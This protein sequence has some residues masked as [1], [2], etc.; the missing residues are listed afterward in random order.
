MAKASKPTTLKRTL[1]VKP[2]RAEKPTF[3]IPAVPATTYVP[4]SNELYVRLSDFGASRGLDVETLARIAL[5][6]LLRAGRFYALDTPLSFGQYAG[7]K[8]ETVIRLNPGY[9]S[10]AIE[11]VDGMCLGEGAQTLLDQMLTRDLEAAD[12]DV[13]L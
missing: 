5:S 2:R 7:E 12:P 1:R 9:V 3:Q 10:W 13:P 4:V 6:G 8:M 11:H